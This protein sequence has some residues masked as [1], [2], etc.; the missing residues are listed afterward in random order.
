MQYIYILLYI[1]YIILYILYIYHIYIYL[2]IHHYISLY[3]IIYH[4]IS[5]YIIIY[6]YISLYIIIYHYISLYIIIYHYIS[7]YIIIYHYISL[8]IICI[9]QGMNLHL[10]FVGWT[11]GIGW[12]CPLLPTEARWIKS[13]FLPMLFVSIL[14]ESPKHRDKQI[15]I[16]EF[17]LTWSESCPLAVIIRNPPFHINFNHQNTMPLTDFVHF[18]YQGM[19]VFHEPT[20][21]WGFE[22]KLELRFKS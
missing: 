1:Y 8:Y 11:F 16:Q 10:L 15:S 4:Y 12:S 20:F 5:L 2:I 19:E 21:V 13:Q 17:G 9:S 7:L 18:R 3:I 6:H 22:S 14:I